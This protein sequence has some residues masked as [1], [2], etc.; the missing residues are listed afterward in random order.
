MF[1][2][3]FIPAGDA[4][5]YD[6]T[7]T[8]EADNWMM[9]LKSGLHRTGEG[10]PDIRNVM[11]DI[12]DDNTI[13][14][15]DALTR[16]IFV[17]KEL[18]ETLPDQLDELAEPIEPV[19]LVELV[20]AAMTERLEAVEPPAPAPIV[21]PEPAP[22]PAVVAAPV[23][24]SAPVEAPTPAPLAASTPAV[25]PAPALAPTPAPASA[26]PDRSYTSGEQPWLSQDGRVRIGSSNFEAQRREPEPTG[27]V[28]Q[29]KR[30]R[31]GSRPA[32]QLDRPASVVSENILE[33][34]FLEIQGL[35]DNDMSMEDAIN[36]VLDMAMDKIPA[37]SGAL[38]FA[39][40]NGQE[41]Y[42][43]AARGPKAKEVLDFRVPMTQGVVGFCAR[44]G[45]SIA[46]SDAPRDAR[47]YRKISEVLSYPNHSLV[48]APIQFEG[49]VYGCIELLNRK[50]S[51]LFAAHEVN[52]LTYIGNQFGQYVNMLIMGREKL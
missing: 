13:H 8:V 40:V 33:D 11:C 47:F 45:V 50:S 19:E 44:E 24:A 21:A 20:A 16:R 36:F 51:S 18:G 28:V 52:A 10:S 6:L 39:E 27:R 49:R 12:K 7:I 43:A 38:L 9:A 32:L 41:L 26:G 23:V 4:D 46:I 37:E 3:V 2:E 48:C 25:A 14:V 31:S 30:R 1:Y 15:T 29:E 42:F 22:T 35:H 34:I 5:G 17:L